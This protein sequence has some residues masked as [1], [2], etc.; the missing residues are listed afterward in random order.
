V[1]KIVYGLGFRKGLIQA[2]KLRIVPLEL[3]ILNTFLQ[4]YF[5]SECGLLSVHRKFYSIER[6]FLFY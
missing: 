2:S 3:F 4:N 6:D 1:E 5:L